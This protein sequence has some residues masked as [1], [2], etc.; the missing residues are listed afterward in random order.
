MALAKCCPWNGIA[1]QTTATQVSRCISVLD[2]KLPENVFIPFL[3]G[4]CVWCVC[5]CDLTARELQSGGFEFWRVGL[6]S[7]LLNCKKPQSSTKAHVSVC[8]KKVPGSAQWEEARSCSLVFHRGS[9]DSFRTFI[10]PALPIQFTVGR[11]SAPFL[12]CE[13]SP[14]Y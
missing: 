1:S 8:V 13:L 5:V 7:R 11:D 12:L 2:R 6:R 14:P 4:V 9:R 3:V 10:P